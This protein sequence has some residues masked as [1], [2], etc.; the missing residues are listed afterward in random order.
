LARE[1]PKY[2][3]SEGADFAKGKATR[4][5]KASGKTQKRKTQRVKTQNAK[6]KNVKRKVKRLVFLSR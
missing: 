4:D 1:N 6:R 3:V 2:N 5:I